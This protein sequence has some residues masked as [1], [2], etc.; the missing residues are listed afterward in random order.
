MKG[1][2]IL[3]VKSGLIAVYLTLTPFASA[4][5]TSPTP[6]SLTFGPT[7]FFP[8]SIP[9]LDTNDI[10]IDYHY[11]I[12]GTGWF[13]L[14]TEQ[15][16]SGVTAG[17]EE[18]IVHRKVDSSTTA[19]SHSIGH[20]T[21]VVTS[22]CACDNTPGCIQVFL[23]TGTTR[24]SDSTGTSCSAWID[25]DTFYSIGALGCRQPAWYS[26]TNN[27]SGPNTN[28]VGCG[29]ITTGSSSYDY[30]QPVG[31]QSGHSGGACG[32]LRCAHFQGS[33]NLFEINL[34]IT[35][36]CIFSGLP[37][38]SFAL[39]ATRIGDGKDGN[40][41]FSASLTPWF[42]MTSVSPDL[43]NLSGGSFATNG[44]FQFSFN[45]LSNSDYDVYAST[46]LAQTSD[47]SGWQ[48]IGSVTLSGTNTQGVFIDTNA[49]SFNHKF[50][51]I[52]QA[53]Y[54][55]QTNGSSVYGFAKLALPTGDSMIS[56]PFLKSDM[57]IS[58]LLSNVPETTTLKFWGET[59]WATTATF[60]SGSWDQPDWP[61]VPGGGAMIHTTTN[62]TLAFVGQVAEGALTNILPAGSSM[63]SSIFAVPNVDELS[64]S[65]T[66]GDYIQKWDGTQ[67]LNYTNSGALTWAPSKPVLS[68]GDAFIIHTSTNKAWGGVS[69][70]AD[71]FALRKPTA[72]SDHDTDL[73]AIWPWA[74]IGVDVPS[75]AFIEIG[76]YGL[77]SEFDIPMTYELMNYDE[78]TLIDNVFETFGDQAPILRLRYR[79][80]N[81]CGP[82]SDW[83]YY[84]D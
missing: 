56:N 58:T 51:M 12:L 42:S 19:S 83:I 23:S 65:L 57:R 78:Q 81:L 4:Q 46:N 54:Y 29:T 14:D 7:P 1:W 15:D 49:A 53:G 9:A 47:A 20:F 2:A 38:F 52:A 70:A 84:Q 32:L 35:T 5:E 25:C 77:T 30:T 33:G 31:G 6:P 80:G 61:L 17:V 16:L 8:P 72:A 69:K 66:N 41:D 39:S 55:G 62:V 50:Y 82:W 34:T 26:E 79:N 37:S 40:G 74:D 44:S 11:K 59:N 64:M 73:Y 75:G 13:G 3:L 45:S 48:Y 63:R 18:S 67:Y 36:N 22:Y 60:S 27:I 21:S 28:T 68:V 10:S 71:V 24:C 76:R 43:M